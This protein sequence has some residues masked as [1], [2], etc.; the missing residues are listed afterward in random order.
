MPDL[1]RVHRRR[2]EDLP[3]QASSGSEAGATSYRKSARRTNRTYPDRGRLEHA[4]AR[5]VSP[6]LMGMC[7]TDCT[8]EHRAPKHLHKS[9]TVENVLTYC[10]LVHY[11]SFLSSQFHTVVQYDTPDQGPPAV[12][13][14]S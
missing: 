1:L 4:A 14:G 5:I 8:T 9:S 13:E 7:S 11:I 10:S 12:L 3:S 2:A 6:A